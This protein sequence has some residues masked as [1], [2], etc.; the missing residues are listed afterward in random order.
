MLS[1]IHILKSITV[2]TSEWINLFSGVQHSTDSHRIL[3]C[4]GEYS[5]SCLEQSYSLGL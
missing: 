4:V 1:I 2:D 3:F 5:I